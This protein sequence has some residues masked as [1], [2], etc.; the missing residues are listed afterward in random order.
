MRDQLQ[1]IASFRR[2]DERSPPPAPP[3]D[4][5]LPVDAAVRE[6]LSRGLGEPVE[7][8]ALAGVDRPLMRGDLKLALFAETRAHAA[9]MESLIVARAAVAADVPFVV[10]RVV[11]DPSNRALPQAA[12]A[13]LTEDGRID[14]GAVAGALL[15]RPWECLDMLT[16]ALDAAQAMRRLRRV[17]RRAAPLLASL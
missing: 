7:G 16:L 12:L 5:H 1:R 4:D 9:D 13:G 17:G 14:R 11:S 8:G 3:I 6:A 15:R 10:L 2:D